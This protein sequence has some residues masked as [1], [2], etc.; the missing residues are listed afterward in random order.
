MILQDKYKASIQTESALTQ[1]RS[2]LL[3]VS[4]INSGSKAHPQ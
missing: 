3:E 1:Q 2:K 4:A